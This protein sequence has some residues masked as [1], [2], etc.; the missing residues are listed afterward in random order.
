[1]FIAEHAQCHHRWIEIDI[2]VDLDV[3]HCNSGCAEVL[4]T[5]RGSFTFCCEIW[6]G[7]ESLFV[8]LPNE[9]YETYP[10]V[11][12]SRHD[13][14]QRFCCI[15]FLGDIQN[16]HHSFCATRF[17]DNVSRKKTLVQRRSSRGVQQAN[18][19]I[20]QHLWR[21]Y[22]PFTS[23]DPPFPWNGPIS[24]TDL[25]EISRH[26]LQFRSTRT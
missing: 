5:S 17:T 23:T 14:S 9:S 26:R 8:I 16:S 21:N 1:M 24:E 4:E 22:F 11:S 13:I 20:M 18:R 12:P 19:R 15:V 10:S 25:L 2:L 6:S 3:V 7:W